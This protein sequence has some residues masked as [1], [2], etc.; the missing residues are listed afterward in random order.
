[1]QTT[2][3]LRVALETANNRLGLALR[4][5]TTH[6]C[7]Q[8]SF[9]FFAQE[10]RTQAPPHSTDDIGKAPLQQSDYPAHPIA[11]SAAHALGRNEFTPVALSL[12]QKRVYGHAQSHAYLTTF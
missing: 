6:N 9:Q 1:M 11:P 5:H 12:R 4:T 8:V 3:A 2:S 10:D 7:N